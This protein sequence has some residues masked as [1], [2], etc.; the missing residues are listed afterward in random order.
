MRLAKYERSQALTLTKMGLAIGG[1]IK[2]G[3]FRKGGRGWCTQ[4]ARY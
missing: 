1:I 3:I 2:C 4:L